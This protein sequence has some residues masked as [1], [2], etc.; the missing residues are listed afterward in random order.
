[1]CAGLF[2]EAAPQYTA[3]LA[4]GTEPEV[5]LW[6][7]VASGAPLSDVMTAGGVSGSSESSYISKLLTR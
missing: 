7:D 6:P 4:R 2:P 1:M 3:I 5:P